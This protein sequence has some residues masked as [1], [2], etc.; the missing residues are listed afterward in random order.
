MLVVELY[1]IA[2]GKRANAGDRCQERQAPPT[3]VKRG[4]L[5]VQILHCIG[6]RLVAEIARSTLSGEISGNSQRP[7]EEEK[8]YARL[9]IEKFVNNIRN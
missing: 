9:T 1:E 7:W 5:A 2:F 4:L 3:W 6:Q 8:H